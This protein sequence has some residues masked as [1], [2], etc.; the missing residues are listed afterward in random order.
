MGAIPIE[1]TKVTRRSAHQAAALLD[2][3][4]SMLIFPEGGRSPDGWGQP[5]RGGAASLA[6]M[7][8]VDS[9]RVERW[10][11]RPAEGLHATWFVSNSSPRNL[12]ARQRVRKEDPHPRLPADPPHAS[13][14]SL[15]DEPPTRILR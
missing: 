15:P 1:R 10:L 2:D 7:F 13:V 9:R 11:R 3:G 12:R 8:P 4:W 5:F 6:R 14:V